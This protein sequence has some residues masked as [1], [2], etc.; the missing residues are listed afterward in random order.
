MFAPTMNVSVV[1]P[2]CLLLRF[3]NFHTNH[4]FVSQLEIA[5]KSRH[6]LNSLIN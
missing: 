1:E 4:S 3:V 5:R 2:D 6:P